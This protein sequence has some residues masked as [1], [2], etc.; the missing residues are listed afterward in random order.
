MN[1]KTIF[2]F[3][4]NLD[5]FENKKWPKNPLFSHKIK[6][7]RPLLFVKVVSELW[8]CS[9]KVDFLTIFEILNFPYFCTKMK[10]TTSW[11]STQITKGKAFFYLGDLFTQM[12]IGYKTLASSWCYMYPPNQQLYEAKNIQ[13]TSGS[14]TCPIITRTWP[15]GTCTCPTGTHICPTGNCTCQS[16]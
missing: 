7:L 8:F 3:E 11:I 2:I 15:P 16:Q 10:S 9:L 4:K 14:G 13:A 1:K 5:F 6:N 12:I